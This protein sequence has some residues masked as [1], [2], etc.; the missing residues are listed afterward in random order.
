[1]FDLSVFAVPP[2]DILLAALDA[3]GIGKAMD[4]VVTEFVRERE[5]DAPLRR[6]GAVVEN[7]PALFPGRR[8]IERTIEPDLWVHGLLGR[9]PI[10][11]VDA[12][13]AMSAFAPFATKLARR[14]N[15]SRGATI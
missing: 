10:N 14:R 8:A 9:V 13:K 5:V 7:P 11:L 1:M 3:V 4:Q 2:Y 12:T 15:V 6:Y